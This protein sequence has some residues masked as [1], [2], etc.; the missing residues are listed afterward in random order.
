MILCFG[1]ILIDRFE[2]KSTKKTTSYVGGAP[3]NVAYQIHQLGHSSLFVG[4]VG[5][6]KEG[7]FIRQ[8]FKEMNLPE[9][10]L[11]T[12][13]KKRTTIAKVSLQGSER[14]FVFERED[15]TDTLFPSSALDFISNADVIHIGSFLLS[16]KESQT[17][18]KEI[19]S[20]CKAQGK[21]LS[22]DINYRSDIF[23][24]KTEA[25]TAYK[26]FYPQFDIVKFS[27]DELQ[28][29]TGEDDLEPALKKLEK[30][31][32][33]YLVTLGKK[34][35]VAYYNNKLV[36]ANSIPVKSVDTTGAG[37]AFFGTFLAN[38]DSL[39]LHETL[40]LPSLLQST[41]K[42]ANIAGALTTTKKGA[43]PSIP[44]LKQIDAALEKNT[45]LSFK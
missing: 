17:Y 5:D 6:D 13:K 37:D 21:L 15:L 12:I 10:G 26:T 18:L 16:T 34:G 25:L 38:I 27:F 1:E 42:Y 29:F 36:K 45:T 19:I 41:L 33:I 2:N 7:A 28:L 20:T 8:F 4:N 43:I 40:F 31:P 14:S 30:G 32:K 22:F 11:T 24:N 39:G 9:T 44:N 35:S 23:K 3:F